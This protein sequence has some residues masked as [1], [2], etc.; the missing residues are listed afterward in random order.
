MVYFIFLSVFF[1]YFYACRFTVN[2]LLCDGERN[3]NLV[4][5]RIDIEFRDG[6]EVFEE[7]LNDDC[8][9]TLFDALQ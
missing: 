8:F 6:V 2:I 5:N 9:L 4:C 1:L 3:D 7:E